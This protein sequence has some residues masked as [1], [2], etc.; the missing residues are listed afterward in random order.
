ME[1]LLNT[2]ESIRESLETLY[3]LTDEERE[4]REERGEESDIRE[5]LDGAP[6][7]EYTIS[8]RGDYLGACVWVCIG[9]LNVWI[10]TRNCEIRGAWG[11]ERAGIWFPYEICDEIDSYMEEM[12][13]SIK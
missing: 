2:C 5:W 9:G 10:D 7:I 13:L 3:N 4:E 11:S 12:Y 8:S 6:D 1:E